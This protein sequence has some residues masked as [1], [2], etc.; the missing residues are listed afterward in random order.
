MHFKEVASCL[1][2][3]TVIVQEEELKKFAE[4]NHI[5]SMEF[6]IPLP[7]RNMMSECRMNHRDESTW[8]RWETD[9]GR[10]GFCC[11]KCGIIHRVED[12]RMS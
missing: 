9:E 6:M 5:A 4:A 3:P 2:I 7:H 10:I 12:R 11:P 1:E 8:M